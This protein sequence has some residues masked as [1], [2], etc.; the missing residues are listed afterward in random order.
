MNPE[1][2]LKSHQIDYTLH[3]HPAVFTCEE[4]E[5]HCAHIPGLDCKNLFLKNKKGRRY[6][7]VILPANKRADLTEIAAIV[8]EKKLSFASAERL[9]EKLGIEPGSVSPFG[10]I[11]DEKKQVEVFVDQQVYNSELVSFHPNRNTASLELS[12]EMFRKYLQSIGHQF[13]LV[14]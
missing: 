12:G 1:D 8:D 4:A 13:K 10:L 3:E 7:L 6:F 11:N 5:I 2:Y 9:K 14:Q